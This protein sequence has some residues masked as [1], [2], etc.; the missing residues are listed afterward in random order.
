MYIVKANVNDAQEL[1]RV[2]VDSWRETYDGIMPKEVLDKKSYEKREALWLK[3]LKEQQSHVYVAKTIDGKIIGFADGGKERTGSYE[4]DGELYAIYILQEY[5]R[6]QL[7]KKLI[8][9]VA[10]DLY[11]N[12]CC[13]MLVWVVASNPS[14]Y[15]YE[16]LQGSCVDKKQIEEL[17]VEEIAYGWKDI[18]NLLI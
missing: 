18:E 13:S 14:K 17:H 11:E 6:N 15:F 10:A 2:H 3:I 8:K 1:A 7:G 4:Y 16:A 9:A 12:G 5:Q